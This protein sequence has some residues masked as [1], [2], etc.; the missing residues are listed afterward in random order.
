MNPE[1][2]PQEVHLETE[3]RRYFPNLADFWVGANDDDCLTL[4]FTLD[5][6]DVS[7]TQELSNIEGSD[8]D[9]FVFRSDLTDRILTLPYAAEEA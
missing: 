6:N 9:Y 8:E 1:L 2:D 3:T 5:G 7:F 4:N